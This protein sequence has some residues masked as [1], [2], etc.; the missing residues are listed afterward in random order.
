[1]SDV[2]SKVKLNYLNTLHLTC[3]NW[4]VDLNIFDVCL[5]QFDQKAAEADQYGNEL[6]ST[7]AEISEL[8]RMITRLQTEILTAK[9]QVSE[10][11]LMDDEEILNPPDNAYTEFHLLRQATDQWSLV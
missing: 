1:M 3:K 8:S 11:C 9:A 7:K 2:N 6:R 4:F 10:K 5:Y